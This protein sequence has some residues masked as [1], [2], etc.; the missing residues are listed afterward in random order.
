M[1]IANGEDNGFDTGHCLWS[2]DSVT[3]ETQIVYDPWTGSG[4]DSGAGT[5]GALLN[6]D[7]LILFV[8][9]NGVSGHELHMWSSLSLTDEWLI[10]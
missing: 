6:S 4:N 2:V 8:A 7:G 10:W 9:D 1:I 3:Y 5:Y